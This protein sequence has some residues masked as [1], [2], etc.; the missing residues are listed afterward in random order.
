VP[1]VVVA[2]E[3]A[4]GRLLLPP[5]LITDPHPFLLSFSL[6]SN[7]GQDSD[8][9]NARP[10]GPS[11]GDHNGPVDVHRATDADACPAFALPRLAPPGAATT[12]FSSCFRWPPAPLEQTFTVSVED[13]DSVRVCLA[14]GPVV[15]RRPRADRLGSRR[16]ARSRQRS[17]PSASPSASSSTRVRRHL[18]RTTPKAR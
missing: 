6:P 15:A 17:T 2:L 4:A 3:A 16:L 18:L 11:P 13:S 9:Q 14:H 5:T 1:V 8:L 7:D 12:S 10:E